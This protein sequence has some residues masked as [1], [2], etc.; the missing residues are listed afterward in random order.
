MV[1]VMMVVVVVVVVVVVSECVGGVYDSSGCVSGGSDG[2][3]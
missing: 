2:V 1:V 3:V